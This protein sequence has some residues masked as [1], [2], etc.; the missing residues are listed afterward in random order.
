MW[1]AVSYIGGRSDVFPSPVEVGSV[2]KDRALDGTLAV[3][4]LLS[5]KRLLLGYFIS[6]VTGAALGVLMASSTWFR[7]AMNPMIAGIQALPSV[8]WLPLGLLWF[9]LSDAAILFV[10]VIGSSLS[11]AISIDAG[12]RNVPPLFI[13]AARTMGANGFTL[14]R[15]VVIPAALP[16]IL[17]GMRL[18]WAF[19]WRSLMAGEL[20]FVTGGLGHLMQTGRELGDMAQVVG[21]MVIIVIVG[22]LSEQLLFIRFQEQLRVTWGRASS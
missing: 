17:T 9:G 11:V 2:L 3:A 21:V 13:R 4:V 14:Y 18:A 15:R 16:E 10:I 6:V 12:A 5:L 22:L 1:V 7:G 20:L 19:A 8:C